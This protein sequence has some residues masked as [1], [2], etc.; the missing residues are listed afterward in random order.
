MANALYDLAKEA[1]LSGSINLA[2]NDIRCVLVDIA[3][4]SVNLTTHQF[5]SSIGSGYRVATSGS[6]AGKSVALGVFDANDIVFSVPTGA[7]SSAVV[8]YKWVSSDGDSP[9]I[10]YIDTATGLPVTPVGEDITIAWSTGA[11]K[12]FAI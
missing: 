12:I 1:L 11:S 7:L 4:Y 10:A 3:G 8:I 5:L 6:L 2:S 9:L